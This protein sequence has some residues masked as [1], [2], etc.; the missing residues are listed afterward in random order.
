MNTALAPAPARARALRLHF[1]RKRRLGYHVSVKDIEPQQRRAAGTDRDLFATQARRWRRPVALLIT[2]LATFAGAGCQPKNAELATTRPA[3]HTSY[4]PP[5]PREPMYRVE[6]TSRAQ[7]QLADSIIG[8]K[9]R[10][11]LRRDA[12]GLA[13]NAPAGMTGRWAAEMSV[14]GTVVEMTD[15]WLVVQADG[16]KRVIVPHASILVIELQE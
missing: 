6:V 7:A 12:L 10:V 3:S 1:A 13:G 5:S 4:A 16:G 11:Q 15:Q 9:C 14:E 8:R 2:A